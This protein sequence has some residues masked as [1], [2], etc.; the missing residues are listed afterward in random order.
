MA[1]V[2]ESV[3]SVKVPLRRPTPPAGGPRRGR[4]LAPAAMVA[5]A[6]CWTAS[7]WLSPARRSVGYGADSYSVMWSLGWLSHAL[8]HGMNPWVSYAANAP[9]G[10]NLM[11]QTAMPVLALPL[12][13]LTLA[14]GPV[15]SYN[16]V[17]TAGPALAGYVAFRAFVRW[18]RPLSAFVGAA[19]FAFSPFMAA[20]GAQHA[21]LTFC[22][23]APL[24]LILLD[25]LLVRQERSPVVDGAL[26]GLV[27]ACQFL[28]AE[29]TLAAEAVVAAVIVAILAWRHP[30][31]ARRHARYG[32]RGMAVAV[33]VAV[34]VV[35][36]PLYEQFHAA[37]RITQQLHDSGRYAAD[38]LSF[39][40]PSKPLLVVPHAATTVTSRFTGNWTEWDSYV[41]I[42]L[43][44]F[45][46]L[47][48][49]RSWWKPTLRF[50]CLLA[51][52]PAVLSLGPSLHVAGHD[53]RVPLPWVAAA[54]VPVLQ[55]LLPTRFAMLMFLGIGL[56]VAVG[57]D[58]LATAR[59]RQ[60]WFSYAVLAA[61]LVAI[62]PRWPYATQPLTVPAAF[63]QQSVCPKAPSER[64][65]VLPF[66]NDTLTWQAAAGYCYS[67][68]SSVNFNTSGTRAGRTLTLLLDKTSVAA[69][70]GH[71][72]P[73]ATAQLRRTIR[74][75]DRR[76]HVV[77]VVLGPP[78][79]RGPRQ[80]RALAQWLTAVLQEQPR[81][82]GDVQVWTLPAPDRAPAHRSRRPLS[83]SRSGAAVPPRHEM[84][85]RV[86]GRP[87]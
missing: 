34:A 13:P 84:E 65:V 33:L 37:A 28:I 7:T 70:H 10:V 57:L 79:R 17:A 55:D 15:V 9:T 19:V 52:V 80:L 44:A 76:E 63:A 26:V 36:F 85:G 69:S 27:A 24:L 29:E 59:G 81:R 45:I 14:A 60:R 71:R 72:L 62:S 31:T 66:Q 51:A 1:A 42:P 20:Q 54:H 41:G 6:V 11:W 48:V 12:T 78:E 56:V 83:S 77:E 50:G 39:V 5:L 74:L 75:Q 82:V 18:T 40:T 16:L 3:A 68:E 32:L 64:I 4:L 23:S 49:V 67:T 8:A 2:H 47:C 30:D 38:A 22:V 87:Q 25:R 86:P 35:A 58:G 21:F 46:A 53:T 61:G 43:L 73:A